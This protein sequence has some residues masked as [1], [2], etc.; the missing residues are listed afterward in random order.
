M[1]YLGCASFVTPTNDEG[2]PYNDNVWHQM[3][4]WRDK[5]VAYISIDGVW[6]G[7]NIYF[8]LYRY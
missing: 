6:E 4:A 3:I 7:L 8:P 5:T 2:L 1:F